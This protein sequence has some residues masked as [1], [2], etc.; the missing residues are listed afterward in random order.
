MAMKKKGAAKG[1]VRKM[2]PGGRAGSKKPDNSAAKKNILW[3]L[4][5]AANVFVAINKLK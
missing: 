1:G 5:K 3:I 4:T 2:K